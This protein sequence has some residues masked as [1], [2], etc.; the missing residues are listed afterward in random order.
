MIGDT[1]NLASRLE[2]L[3][4]VYGTRILA[5]QEVRDAAGPGF[6]WRRV[7]RVAVVGRTADTVVNELLGLRGQVAPAVLAAREQYE[8]AL[9]AY[10]ARRFAEAEAGFRAAA[11]LTGNR[12][13][14]LMRR[15]A[16]AFSGY[17]PPDDWDGVYMLSSKG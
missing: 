11:G 14:E 12:A 2:I 5:S 8:Q 17:P 4:K 10:F 16:E 7:D 6:E 3:N 13:A 15:R 9:A 1:V